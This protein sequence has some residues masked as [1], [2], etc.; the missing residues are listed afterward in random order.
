LYPKPKDNQMKTRILIPVVILAATL[1]CCRKENAPSPSIN[2]AAGPFHSL[3]DFYSQ[4]A[5]VKQIYTI[6]AQTGG[7]FTSPQGT[8][9]DIPSNAFLD[10]NAQPVRGRV[11]IQFLDIYK[12]SDMLLSGIATNSQMGPPLKSGGEFFIK[13]L[14]GTAPLQMASGKKIQ[15]TQPSILTG[16]LDQA[17]KAFVVPDTTG[18]GA[19]AGWNPSTSDSVLV[20][21][22]DYVFNLYKFGMPV[23]SG[24]WC[25]SDNSVFFSQYNQ[26]QLNIIPNDD[27]NS[28]QPDV[29]LVFKNVAAM[30]HVY[31]KV[32]GY[33]YFFAPIG[34][35][36]TVVAVGEK[37]G[38]LYS[39]FTPITI[40]ANQSL[41]FTLSQTTSS[42][43]K[44]QLSA[45]N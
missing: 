23:D 11:T 3:A 31:R 34:L 36:C 26:T 12:K 38:V 24:S 30:V 9:V 20:H 4:N 14:L 2:P 40:T 15:V 29:F 33:P 25:N 7:R 44:T 8:T 18:M 45:L 1:Q 22:T 39:S 19:S 21:V 43:F 13:A 37:D 42:V 17:M 32:L 28:Y 16:P 35:S 27:P 10:K 6:D 41:H 5:P